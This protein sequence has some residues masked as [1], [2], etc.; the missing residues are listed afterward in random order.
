MKQ[1]ASVRIRRRESRRGSVLIPVLVVALILAGTACAFVDL[2]VTER[3]AIHAATRRAQSHESVRSGVEVLLARSDRRGERRRKGANP[4]DSLASRVVAES[5]DDSDRSRIAWFAVEV[6]DDGRPTLRPGAGDESARLNVNALPLEKQHARQARQTL[7]RLGG[8]TVHVADALLDWIDADDEPRE[9]GAET[10]YYSSLVPPYR[11]ANAPI[12][13]VEELLRVRGVT[14]ALLFGNPPAASGRTE[15][16]RNTGSRSF[17]GAADSTIPWIHLLTAHSAESNLRPDGRPL[18]HIN[19]DN[20]VRLFDELEQEL[21]PEAA[22]FIVA[23]RLAGPIHGGEE[24]R[25]ADDDDAKDP[26]SLKADRDEARRQQAR[27]RASSQRGES[28]RNRVADENATTRGGLNLKYR[29]AYRIRSLFDLIGAQVHVPVRNVDEI[30]E[31]PWPAEASKMQSLIDELSA[32]LTTEPGDIVS[33]RVNPTKAPRSVLRGV[34]GMTDEL[35]DRLLVAR[36]RPP[37]DPLLGRRNLG[38]LIQEGV[39][40]LATLQTIAP[41]L[42]TREGDVCRAFCVGAT[43][44][45]RHPVGVEILIDG[46]RRPARVLHERPIDDS[47]WNPLLAALE[48]TFTRAPTSRERP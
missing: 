10:N 7:M 15:R 46:S 27:D 24:V 37:G 38:W 4:S 47:E 19:Q 8:M 28:P 29:P 44:D 11:A 34:D 33:G 21:G 6:G 2:I 31:S 26:D 43:D 48:S 45:G 35:A 12:R 23:Y 39:L 13:H 36:R 14:P 42:T 5:D 9:F 30:L 1:A 17:R 3:A 41:R 20:L 16:E 22:Q 18:I 32:R 25:V 40:D